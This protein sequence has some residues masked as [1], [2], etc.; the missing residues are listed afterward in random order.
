MNLA[1][2]MYKEC[3]LKKTFIYMFYIVA[4][5]Q[6]DIPQKPNGHF[7]VKSKMHEANCP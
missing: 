5:L 4:I 6:V 3:N 7:K 2:V 1:D